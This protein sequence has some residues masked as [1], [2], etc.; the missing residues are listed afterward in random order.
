MKSFKNTEFYILLFILMVTS[1]LSAQN[2]DKLASWHHDKYSMFIHFGVYSELGGVWNG[3]EITDG[4]SEQIQPR[5]GIFTDYYDDIPNRFNPTKWNADSIV[6][7]AKNAGMKTIVI[8]TKHHDGFCMYK[9]GYTNF[10]IVDATPYKKD[11]LKQLSEACK[12]QKINLGLYF[13]L[14]D[15][16]LHPSFS[17]NA[18]TITDLHHQYNLNQVKELLTN[19]GSISELW[20]DMGSLTIAQSKEMYQL[21][22]NLQPDCMV[23]GR[24]GNNAYDFCVMGDNEYP[25]FKIDTPWQTPASIFNETWGYRSWQKRGCVDD[26]VREKLLSLINVVS[27]GGN[28][29]LNIGPKGDGTVVPFEKE[30]LLTIG[31]WLNKNGEAIYGTDASPFTQIYN[32]GE[33]TCKKN[34]L[35]LI[36]T[37]KATEKIVLSGISGNVLAVN[38]LGDNKLKIKATPKNGDLIVTLPTALFKKDEFNIVEIQFKNQFSVKPKNILS[39]NNK[40]LTINNSTKLYSYSCI[41]YYNNFRSIVKQVWNFDDK[42]K[43]VKPTV[44]FTENEI[45]KVL[46][47]TWNNKTEKITLEKNENVRKVQLSNTAQWGKSYLIGPIWCDFETNPFKVTFPLDSSLKTVSPKLIKEQKLIANNADS[48]KCRTMQAYY[49]LYNITSQS[50]QNILVKVFSGDGIQL[51]LN[52]ENLFKHNNPRNNLTSS[53]TVLLQLQKGNNQLLIKSNNRYHDF[54]KIGIDLNIEQIIYK[55]ELPVKNFEGKNNLELKLYNPESHHQPALLH[56]L[57]IQL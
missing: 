55:M 23:S 37:G 38:I 1:A 17:H 31:K 51:W 46:D 22:H 42:R 20:F 41:D 18:N 54:V 15:Y 13:S 53:E 12:R 8:T 30:V 39:T 26:K 14:I 3:K 29:L 25:D 10:N 19:Y 7:L 56:N 47:F 49:Q 6:S 28:Y 5:A 16:R 45:G 35:Y 34:K 40:I 4:Y 9:S 43:T 27:R 21:V 36:L 44:Y 52:G 2:P 33:I 32:W 48:I 24:L 57:L 50:A 11:V